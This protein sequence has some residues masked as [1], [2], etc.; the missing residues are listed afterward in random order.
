PTRLAHL[1][2]S[3][4]SHMGLLFRRDNPYYGQDGSIKICENGQDPETENACKNGAEVWYSRWGYQE[5]GKVHARLTWN[6]FYEA[7]LARLK[8]V[9]ASDVDAATSSQLADQQIG[10]MQ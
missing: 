5:V 1:N 9:L 2:I 7:T 8:D 3:T 4:G 6:P 10:Q